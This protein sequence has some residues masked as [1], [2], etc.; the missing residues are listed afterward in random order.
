MIFVTVYVLNHQSLN[1]VVVLSCF[2]SVLSWLLVEKMRFNF[3]FLNKLNVLI[4]FIDLASYSILK[5]LC[6]LLS[7]FVR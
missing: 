7:D 6:I 5:L 3:F 1:A 4:C 2:A